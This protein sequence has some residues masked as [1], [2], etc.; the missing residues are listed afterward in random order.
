MVGDTRPRRGRRHR[1]PRPYRQGELDALCGVYSIINAIRVLCP[2]LRRAAAADLFD[3]LIRSMQKA[4]V[5]AAIAVGGGILREEL[6]GLARL[7]VRYMA[8]RHNVAITVNPLARPR[9]SRR[10]LAGLWCDLQVCL[11]PSCVAVIELD[12]RHEHWTVAV[13]AT[14]QRLVLFDSDGLH[15]LGRRH[16]VVGAASDGK[17]RI[18]RHVLL[19]ARRAQWQGEAP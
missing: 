7:A 17:M 15:W 6:T 1:R 14:A 12:G 10:D 11:K 19:I 2:E 8:R 13:G 16:C 18:S 5:N 4:G 9:P 3:H